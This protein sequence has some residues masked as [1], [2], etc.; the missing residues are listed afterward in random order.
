MTADL[1]TDLSCVKDIDAGGAVVTGQHLLAE[2]WARR[3]WT[4]RGG[5]IDDPNYG[6][7]LTQFVNADIG[8]GDLHAIQTGIVNECM[9]DERA[10]SCV[11]TV[12]FLAGIM[13]VS[14]QGQ[15]AAGP[16]LLVLAVSAIDVTIS[17]LTVT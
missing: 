17:Q 3:L 6:Y 9:K 14:I 7:D 8:P 10:L 12:T 5:L 4:P 15:D 1:G 11:A 2:G 16:F 13:T